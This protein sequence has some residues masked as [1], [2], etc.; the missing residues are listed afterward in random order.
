VNIFNIQHRK[1]NNEEKSGGK[2][3]HPHRIQIGCPPAL[4]IFFG[5]K[6]RFPEKVL[7]RHEEFAIEM[8]DIR[9]KMTDQM[10]DGLPGFYI[11]L[12]ANRTITLRRGCAAIKTDFLSPDLTV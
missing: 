8:R 11:L 6:A 10:T 9:E 7:H 1:E 5:K 12:A 3:I 4:H 2:D